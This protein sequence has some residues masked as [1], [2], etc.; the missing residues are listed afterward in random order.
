[1]YICMYICMHTPEI[2]ECT[3]TWENVYS[4]LAY[5]IARKRYRKKRE[6]EV[7][8]RAV[9]GYMHVDTNSQ[10]QWHRKIHAH[11]DRHQVNKK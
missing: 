4:T 11:A 8:Y 10:L 5:E 1:M 3:Y 6:K 7:Y 2:S 9:Q